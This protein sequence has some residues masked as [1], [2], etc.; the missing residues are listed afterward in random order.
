MPTSARRVVTGCAV[1]LAVVAASC[2]KGPAAAPSSPASTRPA[3]TAGATTTT[4]ASTTTASGPRGPAVVACAPAQLAVTAGRRGAATGHIGVALL[5]ENTGTRACVL[6]GYPG[7]GGL[8]GAGTQ[9][10]QAVRTPSGFMG[11]LSGYVG[12]P[13]PSVTLT[14][15]ATASA[16][17]EGTDVPTGTATTC[18]SY[19]A[20]LVTPP[21]A[22]QSVHVDASLPGCSGLRVNP[23]VTGT[24][25]LSP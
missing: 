16:L 12:G 3:T 21:N 9:V 7:V 6:D 8:D 1:A 24:T 25:G 11:G 13:V 10:T 15:G 18:A 20:L 22:L 14:P 4:G 2:S 23:V 17:V 19:A 5:F